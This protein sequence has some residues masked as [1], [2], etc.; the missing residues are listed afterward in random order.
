MADVAADRSRPKRRDRTRSIATPEG[1]VIRMTLASLGD[2]LAALVIDLCIIYGTLIALIVVAVLT[3]FELGGREMVL[4]VVNLSAF[5][6]RSFYFAFFELRWLGATPGKRAMKLRVVS[7]DGGPLRPAAVLARNLMREVELFLP[8]T[9]V[10]SVGSMPGGNTLVLP[11]LIWLG[12]ITLLPLFNRDR[13][14][15]GDVVGG[16]WVIEMPKGALLGDMATVRRPTGVE[17]PDYRFTT[18]QVAIYG[19]YELQ[20]LEQ[21]L[22]DDGPNGEN[23]RQA[24]AEKIAAKIGFETDDGRPIWPRPFLEAFYRA[25]RQRLETDLAF[26]RRQERKRSP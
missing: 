7:R 6:V 16:T 17:R 2:R 20:I 1:V 24:V 14:R 4:V 18:E 9:I 8:I 5:F 13:L 15:A 23:A 11:A 25:Q 21:V 10:L 12:V 22:R 26:G 19:I 3:I